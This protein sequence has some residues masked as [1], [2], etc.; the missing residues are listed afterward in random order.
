M[1][2]ASAPWAGCCTGRCS[3]S[4]LSFRT[5][6]VQHARWLR[7][8]GKHG[9][10]GRVEARM[11]RAADALPSAEWWPF[12]ARSETHNVGGWYVE[13]ARPQLPAQMLVKEEDVVR[14]EALERDLA[15]I[16]RRQQCL[17]PA[18]LIMTAAV[19]TIE[20][21]VG[22]RDVPTAL[23]T[24][25]ADAANRHR[26]PTTW[27]GRVQQRCKWVLRDTA[28][29]ISQDVRSWTLASMEEAETRKKRISE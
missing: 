10:F 27:L 24:P 12:P 2:A 16:I 3:H 7:N 19:R 1:H 5:P 9:L 23:L 15:Q 13:L 21:E 8:D 20:Y 29:G 25:S 14:L 11:T 6:S 28:V 26:E 18:V 17:H 22:F 4:L